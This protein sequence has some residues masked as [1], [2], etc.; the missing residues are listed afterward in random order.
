[1]MLN[2]HG[3]GLLIFKEAEL[4]SRKEIRRLNHPL[5]TPLEI[6]QVIANKLIERISIYNGLIYVKYET[7]YE[8]TDITDN[9]KYIS[10]MARKLV[11]QSIC[12]HRWIMCKSEPEERQIITNMLKLSDYVDIIDDLEYMLLWEDEE[13]QDE[14]EDTVEEAEEVEV[15]DEEETFT[16]YNKNKVLVMDSIQQITNFI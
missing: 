4:L 13:E 14:E 3:L 2:S 11:D 15:Q 9:H 7:S 1:M 5:S 10:M 12:T 6:A 16:P 8:E